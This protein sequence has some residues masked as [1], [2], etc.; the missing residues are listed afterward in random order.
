MRYEGNCREIHILYLICRVLDGSL[1][2][3]LSPW[4]VTDFGF[5][6]AQLNWIMYVMVPLQPNGFQPLFL[7]GVQWWFKAV[8]HTHTLSP[9]VCRL[10]CLLCLCLWL[11]FFNHE[12]VFNGEEKRW[13]D[14]SWL[15]LGTQHLVKIYSSHFHLHHT[16]LAINLKV[17]HNA[18]VLCAFD[19]HWVMHH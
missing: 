8:L 15:T 10:L 3:N 17:R 1:S 13:F 16:P 9:P 5:T 7:Q 11:F 18:L 12:I 14:Q 2:V 4:F 19:W 6:F